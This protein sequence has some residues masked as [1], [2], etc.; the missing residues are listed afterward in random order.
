MCPN[1]VVVHVQTYKDGETQPAYHP[2]P[3][4]KTHKV[5]LDHYRRESIKIIS[6]LKEILVGA[7]VG[8]SISMCF[9]LL[10]HTS[11]TFVCEQRRL[12]LTKVLLSFPLMAHCLKSNSLHRLHNSCTARNTNAL[13]K[14]GFCAARCSSRSGYPSSTT[15]FVDRMASIH[16]ASFRSMESHATADPDP[17]SILEATNSHVNLPGTSTRSRSI[18]RG[19]SNMA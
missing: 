6:I 15:T 14:F 19:T 2:N 13:S 17:E 7:E 12:L 8:G 4:N 11:L 5:S 1:L 3:N 18:Q 16:K 10:F 9:Y